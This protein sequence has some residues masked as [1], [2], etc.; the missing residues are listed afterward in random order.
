MT[1]EQWRAWAKTLDAFRVVPRIMVTLYGMVCVVVLNW[2]F[3]LDDPTTQ[4]TTFAT[5]IWG[6]AAAWFHF[7]T[8]TGNK[9]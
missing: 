5:A 6:A 3:G 4:Q 8:A 2:Y 9:P 1:H 7:Y